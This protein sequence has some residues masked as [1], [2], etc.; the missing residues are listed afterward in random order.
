MKILIT[1]GAGFIG[2]QLTSY[3]QRFGHW[4]RW[5]DSLDPQ[6][7]GAE[8]A[9][10][11]DYCHQADDMVYGDVR[12]RAD[13]QRALQNADAVVHLAAQTGIGQ[14][15]YRVAYYIDV[16]IGGTG[17]LWDILANEHTNVKKV[18][19]ASSRAIYGEGAYR[20]SGQCG[21]VVPS[22]RTKAQLAA[23]NWALCCPICGG[24]A[25]P[26]ATPE[27]S[28]AKPASLYACTKLAQEQISLTMSKALGI[29]TIILR[30]QNV[31]G[32]GQSMRNPYTGI[33]SI[34][35]NQLRQNLPIEIYEDGEESRDFVYVEDVAAACSN[36][37][38]L[39]SDATVLNVGSGQPTKVIN[40]AIALKRLWKSNSKIL[41]SGD[42]RVGDI[43]HNWADIKLI[44]KLW[45]NWRPTNLNKGLEE[46]VSWAQCQKV[47]ENQS[48]LAKNELKKR[49][50]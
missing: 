10:D 17:V 21:L 34:F 23:G 47:F 39:K 18:I 22:P 1:G 28:I 16:N 32:P 4:I 41:I 33:I 12:K 42:Y 48:Q 14:S 8:A 38:E 50:L 27:T 9:R 35:S 20:C 45:P 19:V 44:T 26:E 46:F 11:P 24:P 29:S 5:L 2:R 7:H 49:G 37:L 31:F 25:K 3:L 43:R 13:W 15:M 36:A 30:Y 6:I 40:L